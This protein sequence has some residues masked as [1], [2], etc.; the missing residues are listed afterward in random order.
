VLRT[1][2]AIITIL[3][4]K[5]VSNFYH[6]NSIIDIDCWKKS[7]QKYYNG[8]GCDQ[9]GGAGLGPD[10]YRDY[11]PLRSSLRADQLP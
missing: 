1:T 4:A 6:I 2:K 9:F 7:I 5:R 3:V 10:N 8:G 11:P